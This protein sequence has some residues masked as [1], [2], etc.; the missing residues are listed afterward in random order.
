MTTRHETQRTERDTVIRSLK[1]M[2]ALPGK[3]TSMT[4]FTTPDYVGDAKNY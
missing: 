3:T 4:G 2:V 1:S